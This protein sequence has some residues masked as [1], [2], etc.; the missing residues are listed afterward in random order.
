[1]FSKSFLIS[2]MFH[3]CS[4]MVAKLRRRINNAIVNT[5]KYNCG[6][7]ISKKFAPKTG[8]STATLFNTIGKDLFDHREVIGAIL[9]IF[10]RVERR[11]DYSQVSISSTFYQQLFCMKVFWAA[12]LHL[13]FRFVRFLC[14][15]KLAQK[16]LIKCWWNWPQMIMFGPKLKPSFIN[17]LD[18]GHRPPDVGYIFDVARQVI[19]HI[20]RDHT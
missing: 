16:L 11:G 5:S 12:L 14:E 13:H 1:M 20:W 8:S 19:Q 4:E 6:D 17:W 2:E 7:L 10:L 9:A 15:R 18:P 3:V